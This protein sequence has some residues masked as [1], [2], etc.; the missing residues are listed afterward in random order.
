MY[1]Q[2]AIIFALDAIIQIV[3]GPEG[4][5]WQFDP[6]I[7]GLLRDYEALGYRLCGIF[8]PRTFGLE[9]ETQQEKTELV[10]YINGLLDAAGAPTFDAVHLTEDVTD[11][12]PL[13]EMRRRFGFDLNGSILVATGDNYETLRANAGIGRLEWARSLLGDAYRPAAVAAVG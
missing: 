3:E 9:I 10:A 11:P 5:R 8:D 6:K 13:W 1:P 12:R 7:P 4:Y 2:R